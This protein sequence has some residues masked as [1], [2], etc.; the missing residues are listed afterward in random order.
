MTRNTMTSAML[1]LALATPA[2]ADTKR[3]D[4]AGAKAAEQAKA[5]AAA[6]EQ[7][8]ARETE[9]AKTVEKDKTAETPEGHDNGVR[10][11]KGEPERDKR[12]S[13]QRDAK[14]KNQNGKTKSEQPIGAPAGEAA[15]EP[16]PPQ[17]V[18][19]Q[20][21]AAPQQTWSVSNTAM[22]VL[23]TAWARAGAPDTGPAHGE[24][25]LVSFDAP[26]AV[27][28]TAASSGTVITA[29]GSIGGIRAAPAGNG[30]VYQSLSAG[31]Q[32]QFDFSGWS[33]RR[34]LSSLSFEWGSIDRYNFVDFLDRRGE[35]V[36]TLAGSALP[37]F[38]GNQLAAITNQRLFVN[39]QREAQ[40]AAVR[41]RSTGIAFEFDSIAARA[42]FGA[43]AV[44]EPA[45]WTMLIIGFGFI[46]FAMRRRLRG[47]AA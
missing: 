30:S 22:P 5:D 32:S 29:A 9:S 34:P 12:D 42:D 6:K 18:A 46:G 31:S 15:V 16:S 40:I 41:L 7:L 13:N 33:G 36:W 39:F 11:K 2:N 37:Q 45:S 47:V 3:D 14:D 23:V 44:P 4:M 10:D 43:G 35:T 38:D 20:P 1:L 26:N 28:V 17:P 25:L 27:G 21:V 8:R 19:P 24:S